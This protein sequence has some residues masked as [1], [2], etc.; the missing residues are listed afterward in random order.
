MPNGTACAP[1]HRY[2]L[3]FK[4]NLLTHRMHKILCAFILSFVSKLPNA[5][6]N[7]KLHFL[8]AVSENM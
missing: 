5:L 3:D 8:S 6:F 7:F 4:L 1:T 2:I